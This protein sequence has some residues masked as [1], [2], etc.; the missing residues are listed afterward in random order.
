V[1]V[2]V[3]TPTGHV[4]R[5]VLRLLVRAGLRPRALVRDPERLDPELREWVDTVVVDLADSDAVVAA[6]EGV[7]ALYWVDPPTVSDD[8]IA[9]Y[10]RFGANA[11]RAVTENGVART[12]FQSSIG[13]E[14]RTGAG[15]I[16]GLARTEE[17]LEATGASVTH[18]RC[19][20]F[21]TNLLFDLEALQRGVF[22]V[23]LPPDQPMPWVAPRDIAE[24]AAV[25][26]LSTA[27]S[28]RHV[29][30]VHGPA[31]LSWREVAD[32][33]SAATGRTVR[34]ERI[35]DDALRAALTDSGMP[36]GMVDGLLGMST[37]LRDGF[38]PEQPRDPTTTT[39]TTLAA[40]AYDT[41]RPLVSTG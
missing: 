24:T 17:L 33:V 26:L 36:D 4:G 11:A 28:G 38:T 27:W 35:S 14:K 6:T 15:E 13:A 8:P 12:V 22:S 29:Q 1:Q 31:D 10:A 7:E 39:A 18:L 5:E 2:A 23:L 25:R 40:W 20:Y 34:A 21:F 30:A 16:D 19:G 41:L 37:G 32:I 9:A 3:S